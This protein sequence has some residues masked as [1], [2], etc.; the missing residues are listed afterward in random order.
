MMLETCW[1]YCERTEFMWDSL[2]P[3]GGMHTSGTLAVKV[4]PSGRFKPFYGDTVIFSLSQPMIRWLQGIQAELYEACGTCLSERI[5]PETFHITLHDLLNHAEHMPDGAA[6]NMQEAALAIKEARKQMPCSIAIFSKCMF[7]MVDT[8]VVMGFEPA[9]EPDCAALMALYER[10]QQ[11]VLLSYPLTLHV[12][13]AYY[14][15]GEYDEEVLFRLRDAM[16]HIG[17][18]RLAWQLDMHNL[19]YAT[20]ESMGRYHL[21]YE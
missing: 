6:R 3:C 1:Q 15:P 7:S 12:T 4:D 11:V 19:A 2:A 21:V 8:S 13:L 18:Q 10:F 9:T 14:K 17:R 20:F 5:P 16:Q